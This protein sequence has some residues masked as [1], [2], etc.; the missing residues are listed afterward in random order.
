MTREEAISFGEDRLDL[1]G[2]K[3]GE[4]INIAVEA[5]KEQQTI[6][7]TLKAELRKLQTYKLYNGD[8]DKLVMLDNVLKIINKYA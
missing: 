1:F 8:T 6:K 7:Q 2:G 5:L 4:F 3:M